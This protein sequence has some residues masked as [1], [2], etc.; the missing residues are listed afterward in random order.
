M[1]SDNTDSFERWRRDYLRRLDRICEALLAGDRQELAR[2]RK[3]HQELLRKMRLDET[4]DAPVGLDA[5]RR[6]T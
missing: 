3:Q 1:I 2:L 4:S 6:K 5:D